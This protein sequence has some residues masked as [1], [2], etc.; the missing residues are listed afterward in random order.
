VILV[1]S[2][3]AARRVME[4]IIR[5]LEEYL[6]LPVNRDKSQVA[7]VKDITFLGFQIL[8]RKDS[9]KQQSPSEV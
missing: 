2:E 4:G 5:D 1:K 9:G 8:Q 7:K 6:G 3:R